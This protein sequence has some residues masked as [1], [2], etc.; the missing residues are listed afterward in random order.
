MTID[1]PRQIA[2][3]SNETGRADHPPGP[4]P[5]ERRR[6]PPPAVD[7]QASRK[8][9]KSTV[10]ANDTCPVFSSRS[11]ESLSLAPLNFRRQRGQ[12]LAI[13]CPKGYNTL[14]RA[15]SRHMGFFLSR[16]RKIGHAIA[17]APES[18]NFRSAIFAGSLA[19][20]ASF[21]SL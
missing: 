21:P 18:G 9:R 7:R 10:L 6:S 20:R 13:V 5:H 1:D 15:G 19:R 16:A 14:R 12:R 2:E 8:R 11:L 17:R 3:A 4:P